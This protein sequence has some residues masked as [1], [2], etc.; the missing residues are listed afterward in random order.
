MNRQTPLRF[1][2]GVHGC[3]AGFEPHSATRKPIY[4]KKYLLPGI[5]AFW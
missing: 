3:G 1:N 4:R 2:R 5:K